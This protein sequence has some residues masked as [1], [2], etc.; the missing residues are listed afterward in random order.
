MS[1]EGSQLCRGC[2]FCCDGTLFDS[3]RLLDEERAQV[4]L[5]VIDLG[6]RPAVRFP[7]PAHRGSCT[8]YEERPSTCRVYRCNLLDRV[9]AAELD[10][11]AAEARVRWVRAQIDA[12][13]PRLPGGSG[14]FWDAVVSLDHAPR[15]WK[16]EH[17]TLLLALVALRETL[18][19][20]F[21]ERTA[22]RLDGAR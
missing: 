4:R 21:D 10:L 14:D 7:C 5:P 6:G 1:A 2:G 17:A 12:L 20:F 11:G 13:R 19:R 16:E 15:S 9:E 8:L 18:R 22:R 3:L